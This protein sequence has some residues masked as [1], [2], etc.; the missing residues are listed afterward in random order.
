VFYEPPLTDKQRRWNKF[1]LYAVTIP[2]L[3]LAALPVAWIGTVIVEIALAG[4]NVEQGPGLIGEQAEK[5]LAVMVMSAITV[6]FAWFAYRY[7]LK[8]PDTKRLMENNLNAQE[9]IPRWIA[10]E[11]AVL[12]VI[13][14]VVFKVMASR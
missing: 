2:G 6:I 1:G 13:E 11:M 14:F 8:K 5:S 7:A 4:P 3:I 9:W 10:V 12:L